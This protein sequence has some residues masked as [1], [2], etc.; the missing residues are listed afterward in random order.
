MCLY[1]RHMEVKVKASHKSKYNTTSCSTRLLYIRT[2][3]GLKPTYMYPHKK[4]IEILEFV[5]VMH[6]NAIVYFDIGS[7]ALQNF[8]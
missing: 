8:S 5:F 1:M 7:K 6:I 4:S 3:I 2:E